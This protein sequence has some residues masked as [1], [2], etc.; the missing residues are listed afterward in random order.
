MNASPRTRAADAVASL[1]K[2][3]SKAGRDGMAR[4]GLPSDNAFGVPMNQIQKLAKSLGRDHDLAAA[5]WETGWYEARLLACYVDSPER[6]TPA[7]MDRW[8]KDFDNWGICD[9][10][11]FVLFDRTPHAFEKVEQWS[12]LADEFGRRASFALLASVALHD[13]KADDDAFR[14]CFPL[15]EK[16]ASDER[17]FVKKGVS[18]AL[19]GIGKRNDALRREAVE[20]AR[21]L[22]ASTAASARWVGKDALR[23]LAK[24]EPPPRRAAARSKPKSK[25]ATDR[26]GS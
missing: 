9:T 13:K 22:S 1:K 8:R 11:C 4:Y 19:R 23:D 16:A 2:L 14:R 21:R 18:W 26:R 12:R 10:V 17:N 24:K 25:K 5:L 20:L 15:I 6:V 3:G 7:Q